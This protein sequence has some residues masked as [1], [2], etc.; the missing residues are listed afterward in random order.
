[1][2]WGS[3]PGV[4]K[5][6][7]PLKKDKMMTTTTTTT[8]RTT[9]TTTRRRSIP[10]K[11]GFES[12]PLSHP[13]PPQH[14]IDALGLPCGGGFKGHSTLLTKANLACL[15]KDQA[16]H[17]LKQGSCPE[18]LLEMSYDCIFFKNELVIVTTLALLP[19]LQSFSQ[20]LYCPNS[21]IASA[22][23]DSAVEP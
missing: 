7:L 22:Q 4:A 18:K 6:Q 16:K 9:T 11:T 14:Q 21:L 20:G 2:D 15:H 17:A 5:Q 3:I 12:T 13:H 19:V 23:S 8:T 1:M 10:G